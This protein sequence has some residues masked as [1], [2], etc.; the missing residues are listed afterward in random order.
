VIRKA[1]SDDLPLL[2]E[3]WHEFDR[4]IPLPPTVAH[5][6]EAD[7]DLAEVD[8][9][10]E[11]G[12]ALIAERDGEVVGFATG[13][14]RGRRYGFLSN[15][16][17]RPAAR[18]SGIARELVHGVVAELR[19]QGAESI[20]LEVV[21]TNADAQAIYSRW[22]FEP[23]MLVLVADA[24][25][26]EQR[27]AERSHGRTFG[28]VHVQTDDRAVVERTVAKVL[29][30]LGRSAGTEVS[31]PRNGWTAVYDE[32]CDREPKQLQ[33]LARE[34]SYTTGTPSLSL[35][36]EDGAVVRY[37]LYDRGGVVDEYLSVPEYYGALPPG[38][39]VA[40]GANPT[41]VARLTGA[42]PARVRAVARTAA[43]PDQL[44]PAEDLLREIAATM[45]IEG[46]ERGWSS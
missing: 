35:G 1:T 39:A 9:A 12:V 37:A 43:S 23:Y 33:R 40:L 22:G 4:E 10:V 7:E 16:Y 41:V 8:A 42:D 45:G 20:E 32:L 36:V 11:E 46:A 30:R 21:S 6:E 27:L 18:R 19:R 15:V 14:F 13:D 29:P 5:D 44:P 34:L 25:R 28:S 38:D 24:A 26:L 17:V 3:L 31:Q 2:H